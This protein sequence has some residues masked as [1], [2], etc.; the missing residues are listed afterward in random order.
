M[1]RQSF[2]KWALLTA[3]SIT[4]TLSLIALKGDDSTLAAL[5]QSDLRDVGSLQ[6]VNENGVL[7][8]LCPLKHTTVK[9]SVSGFL[10][11]VTVT[12]DFE[13][14][15][16][17]KIEAVYTF[18][19]PQAA[20]VDDLTMSIGDR[21]IK[22][23]I[24]R[25][26]EAQ[27]AY[28]NAKKMGQMASL[29]AQQRPNIFTQAVANIMPGEKI[30]VTISYVETLKYEDGA[31]EWTFP[32]VVGE[33]YIPAGESTETPN[34]N[35]PAQAAPVPDAARLNPPRAA[36]G[37]R[38]GHD[39]SL[40]I[41]LDS[42][43][44]IETVKSETHETEVERSGPSRAVVRLKE[45]NAIPNKD[46]VL[47]F[48]VAGNSIAD[49]VL[50]HRSNTGGFF[51]LILQPPQRVD[52]EDVMPK[53]LVFVLD[54]SGSMQ[55]F[56]I[57]KAKE[58]MKLALDN[59]YPHDTFNLITFSGDTNILFP[60][61]VPAT[62]E[63]IRKA[64]KFLA[65]R[66]SSG[67]TE[68]MKA[69]K[70]AL[71]P[72]DS[73]QHL[74][75]ACFMTDGHVG[76]D[77]NIISEVQKH[78][79]ARVFA[80]G[81]SG[82]PNRFLLDKMAE[83]GRGEV[84]YIPA[85][86][87]TSAAAQRFNERIRNPLLTN[88]SV[89]LTGLSVTDVYPRNIPD[90]FGAK[91]VIL[92]GRY[93]QSGTGTIR[94]KGKMAGQDYVREIPVTLPEVAPEHDVLATLWARRRIDD[95]MGQDMAGLQSG[96]MQEKPREEITQLGLSFKLMTQF[97]SFVAID[98]LTNT[99]SDASRKVVVPAES[100]QFISSSWAISETV[101][102]S[103][104]AALNATDSTLGTTVTV[105]S[106]EEL[107]LQ[108]RSVQSLVTLA[109]G[110]TAI[111][112]KQN[113]SDSPITISTNGQRPNSNLFTIDGVSA[114][115]GIAAGG[116][117]PGDS[118]AG[119]DP[120]LTAGGG[121]N[122][123]TTLG[124]TSEVVINS[125]YI[126]PE[127]GRMPGA[128]VTL[129]TRA[130]TNNFHG[131]LFQFFG[132][133]ALDANDWFANRSGLKR[134]ARRLNN[135]GATFGGPVSRDKLFFFGSYEGLRLRQPITAIT[136]VP[137]LSSRQAAP[138][139][140]RPFLNAFSTPNGPAS[141]DGLAEFAAAFSNPA[142][143][144]A[145][146]IRIDKTH[147]RFTF[148]GRYNFANSEANQRGAGGLS[149][150]TINRIR[151]RTQT[152]TGAISYVMSPSKVA[153]FRANY[154]RQRVSGSYFLDNFGG[155]MVPAPT[156][157]DGSFTFDLNHRNASLMTGT[158]TTNTQHQV[159]LVGSTSIISGN[160]SLKLGA[161]Y[162]RLSPIIGSRASDDGVLF[163]GVT[164]ALTGVA[165]RVNHFVR[166]GQQRPVFHNLSVYAQDEWRQSTRLTLTYG[167]RWEL[168]PAPSTNDQKEIAVEQVNDISQVRLA[169]RGTPLWSTTYG[170]FAP[171]F[172]F[173]YQLSKPSDDELVVRGGVGVLYDLGQ[174]R[175][176]DVFTDSVPFLNG[177]SVFNAPFNPG[178]TITANQSNLPFQAFDPALK[179]PYTLQWNL[180]ITRA[181]G[182]VQTISAAY[183][184]SSGRRLSGTETFLGQNSDFQFLRLTSN[185]AR[186]DY[187]SM[188]LTFDRRL[189]SRFK[190]LVS[191][192]W[193]RSL[194]NSS[195]DSAR[196][197][198]MRSSNLEL[199][200]GPSD[201]DVRHALT[202]FVTY[203]LPTPIAHGLGNSL[204]RNWAVDSI[205]S[206]RSARPLNV[207]YGVPTSFGF[208]Y[209][210]P[211]V[212]SGVPVY[213]SD[214]A[215][216]GGMRLNP[217]AF[218]APLS[219]D[220]GNLGRNSLRGFPLYQI[221]VALRRRFNFTESVSL[222]LQADAFNVL[223]HPNFEDPIGSDLSIGSSFGSGNTFSRNP[224]F[225]Q[226]A[227]LSGRSV[228]AGNG[229]GS[230][231]STGG[232]RAVR[233]S[234]KL[235]F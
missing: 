66:E 117:S 155:A 32:M 143:H 139:T 19:L 12:Q 52:A 200:R 103:G 217:D 14:P 43:V 100:E 31:Y 152:I 207:V 102:V 81:F 163:D 118:A 116:Q 97:T 214:A 49:A 73:Q 20:A 16:P 24:M 93:A 193:S 114:N 184:G 140:V 28:N 50:T 29:L 222:Q 88:I 212:V 225:G 18:P 119:N 82:S 211:D 156:I 206:A 142:Q 51:T 78:T 198:L 173:S 74:R 27:A 234:L 151:S 196:S 120:A 162:R 233:V 67:G 220:Q 219:L 141:G 112:G 192:S 62:E 106:V 122:S 199:D 105:R 202:G 77:M 177:A 65:S 231:Y 60:E 136:D 132:N 213:L 221:D 22:G 230:F 48:Q 33:R 59:L 166:S 1:R 125:Y 215:S 229:F 137:T 85:R 170:N 168:N 186:S 203:E 34:P 53:E 15:F 135:F 121:A 40:E 182:N 111:P 148:T 205:V 176:G 157:T 45:Q 171:R 39:V 190:T 115:F 127:F 91:P 95:L 128:Q 159:N 75:I 124:G 181:I 208:A 209:F 46:F 194:D 110:T 187:R 133:D 153:E 70:A 10:S 158:E 175:A 101:T 179:L 98:E 64:Q 72:S 54:T 37:T 25:R 89:E 13:N 5:P 107:P 131:S 6:A 35:E 8:G 149:L 226:S 104:G 146:S 69:I 86:G 38:A 63:N 76:D 96:K 84:D 55:G 147:S 189:T 92:S 68:M 99:G 145:G 87:D 165:T 21:T 58:T 109:P 108:G 216:P 90:L 30:R 41:K 161:D 164:Q 178:Q 134:P 160:H 210:R 154:S 26:D 185:S 167:V 183:V 227:S 126:R 232:P 71:E 129:T 23:K 80:M 195:E 191:Y 223:N 47:K 228:I 201:F 188:Q 123:F 56:P 144:D 79:N 218:K 224:T 44:P 9:A 42:G 3:I 2:L 113:T 204:L 11:R 235:L 61:P 17:D 94:L 7:T 169:P 4:L 36:P 180:S 83:Y 174:D 130:G 150:S 138:P 172:G 57:D 197:A